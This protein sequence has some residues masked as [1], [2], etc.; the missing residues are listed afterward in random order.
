MKRVLVLMAVAVLA[1]SLAAANINPSLQPSTRSDGTPAGTEAN[2]TLGSLTIDATQVGALEVQ[3]DASVTTAGGDGVPVVVTFGG[4]TYTLNNQVW[5]YAQ[6]YDSPWIDGCSFWDPPGQNWCAVD[7]QFF[8]NSPDPLNN[9]ALS[10]TA[11]VPQPDYYQTFVLARAGLTWITTGFDWFNTSQ[12]VYSSAVST[13]YI[14]ATPVPT[15]TPNPLAGG[16]PVPTL[17]ITGIVALV[18]LIAGVAILV[19]YRRRS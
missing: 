1:S 9:F 6:I 7:D 15:A 3:V 14:D 19:L 18:V 11:T 4:N 10:F 8:M 16:N 2:G 5:L 17:D 12:Y 13:L